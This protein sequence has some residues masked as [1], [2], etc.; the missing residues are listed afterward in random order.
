MKIPL[1]ILAIVLLFLLTPSVGNTQVSIAVQAVGDTERKALFPSREVIEF[2]R[3]AA[4]ANCAGCHG[5]DGHSNTEGKPRLAG[6]RTVYLY[7]VL[8]AFQSG[9][10][11]DEFKNHNAFL[12][13]EAILSTAVYYASL[14]PARVMKSAGPVEP[15]EA[16]E[17]TEASEQADISADDPFFN[18]RASMKKCIKC[19]GES[20]Q[21]PGSGMPSLTAQDPDYFLTSMMAYVDGGR[22]HKLMK[23]LAGTLDE[24][25]LKEMGVFYA[26]QEPIQ[27]ETRGEGDANIGRRLSEGCESCHGVNGNAKNPGTPTLAGQDAKYFIKALKHYKDGKRKHQKMFEAVEA[28][29]EQEMIDLATY[30]ASEE[31]R[32]RDVRMPLKST[33]WITRCERCHGIDGNSSD[34][35]FP[36]LAGQDETY[37]KNTLKAYANGARRNTTMFAMAAPLSTMD[38]ERIGAYFASQQPKAVIY[39]SMPCTDEQN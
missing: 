23:R 31:P 3:T 30:Y 37:L 34:P 32:R 16:S 15:T 18:I 7:R 28:L 26:V 39:M 20:G 6:Q 21:A 19:H 2:G 12:N 4:Q 5:M 29:N 14:T 27:T 8:K 35:R 38:I 10:R 11:K 22:S 33:E 1:Q 25:T 9:E 13:D 36:M 17:L 24:P